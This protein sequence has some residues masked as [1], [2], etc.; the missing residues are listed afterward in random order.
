MASEVSV[1][2][3]LFVNGTAQIQH[4]DNSGRAK[5]E[6]LADNS[7]QL[8]IAQFPRSKGINHDGGGLCDAD[9]IGQLDFTFIGQSCRNDI[10]RYITG[11]IRCGTVNLGAV[12]S[13]EGSAAVA[14]IS[15]VSINDNF[16]A[17]QTAVAMRS[18]DYEPACRVDKESGLRN[19]SFRRAESD[20]T[21]GV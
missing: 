5:V 4:F 20:Q 11:R 2:C 7:D 16:A 17:C 10:F 12:L 19:Q 14:G 21:H 9:G 15:A 3:G 18:S 1:C 8:L 13:G 6:M